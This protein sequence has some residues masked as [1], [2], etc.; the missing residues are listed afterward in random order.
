MFYVQ[1]DNAP[2]WKYIA[3]TAPAFFDFEPR[4]EPWPDAPEGRTRREILAR[5]RGLPVYRGVGV[6]KPLSIDEAKALAETLPSP[7]FHAG[8]PPRGLDAEERE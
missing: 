8:K 2:Y 4:T 6:V 5:K 7:T 1:T 3:A